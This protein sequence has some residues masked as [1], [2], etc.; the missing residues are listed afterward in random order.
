MALD[1][2]ALARTSAASLKEGE[3]GRWAPGDRPRMLERRGRA[4]VVSGMAATRGARKQE[5]DALPESADGLRRELL[6]ARRQLAEAEAKAERA[7]ERE[8]AR[9]VE[10]NEVLES[11]LS[12]LVKEIGEMRF[13]V[14]RVRALEKEIRVRD[15]Q[16]AETEAELERVRGA[17]NSGRPTALAAAAA[18]RAA[19]LFDSRRSS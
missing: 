7:V 3:F 4:A 14:D 19:R 18:S 8:T 9:L 12:R 13:V 16:I 11:H 10:E 2:S 5:E 6:R 1:A 15:A 17:M